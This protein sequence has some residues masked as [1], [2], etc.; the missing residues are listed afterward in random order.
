MHP[1]LARALQIS[2]LV[3]AILAIVSSMILMT[4]SPLG[5]VMSLGVGGALFAC[6]STLAYKVTQSVIS[7]ISSAKKEKHRQKLL[8]TSSLNNS[9]I[10]S[11]MEEIANPTMKESIWSKHEAM[12]RKFSQIQLHLTEQQRSIL[13][14]LPGENGK[15][16]EELIE[17]TSNSYESC[18]NLLELRKKIHQE[19]INANEDTDY[20]IMESKNREVLY[21]GNV[22]IDKLSV[23]G[24][25]FSAKFPDLSKTMQR[26]HTGVSLGFILGGIACVGLIAVLS[27]PAGLLSIPMIIAA[28]I[29]IGVATLCVLFALKEILKRT[30]KNKKQIAEELSD[31]LDIGHLVSISAQ[32]KTLLDSF[33]MALLKENDLVN[34]SR[35]YYSNYEE[36]KRVLTDLKE[37]LCELQFIYKHEKKKS[38]LRLTDLENKLRNNSNFDDNPA[39]LI[40]DKFDEYVSQGVEN[41]KKRREKQRK[42]DHNDEGIW[43]PKLKHTIEGLWKS[44]DNL[45]LDDQLLLERGFTKDLKSYSDSINNLRRDIDVVQGKLLEIEK[46]VN[47]YRLRNDDISSLF[48]QISNDSMIMTTK[49]L[50]AQSMLLHVLKGVKKN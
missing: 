16:F 10:N 41:A 33:K 32:Q 1:K 27:A 37:R 24:G 28:A 50:E 36:T 21:L 30:Q 25:V 35:P 23:C 42:H 48:R 47:K 34:D 12:V 3:I 13:R 18:L 20:L 46:D 11:H 49:L 45:S 4:L 38:D 43:S 29:G 44:V 15:T 2:V 9:R 40:D 31:T 14:H 19:Q 22:L 5:I 8:L 17:N 6:G 39:I 7:M 26:V